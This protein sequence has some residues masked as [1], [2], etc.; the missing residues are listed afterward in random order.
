MDIKKF[1]T[2]LSTK[3][4]NHTDQIEQQFNKSATEYLGSL[5]SKWD[6]L[7]IYIPPTSDLENLQDRVE[8]E[9]IYTYLAG[10][11]PSFEPVRV[12]SF[13]T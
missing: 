8:Q 11:D 10:L 4:R 7:S 1:C 5:K 13:H 9:R 12:L 2:H 3:T 6:E